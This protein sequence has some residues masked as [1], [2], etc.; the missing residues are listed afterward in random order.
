MPSARPWRSPNTLSVTVA[1]ARAVSIPSPILRSS[2]CPPPLLRKSPSSRSEPFSHFRRTRS[3]L[4]SPPVPTV[5][6][7][8]PSGQSL[9][10]FTQALSFS[11]QFRGVLQSGVHWTFPSPIAHGVH[12][13]QVPQFCSGHLADLCGLPRSEERRV[14]KE[15]RSRWS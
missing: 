7:L 15:C 9:S 12:D 2:R 14:G 13:V 8:P 6:L 1:I 11:L 3:Q 10:K 4:S 5:A